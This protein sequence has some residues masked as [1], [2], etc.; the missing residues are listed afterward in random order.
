MAQKIPQT[1]ILF[2]KGVFRIK[3]QIPMLLPGNKGRQIIASGIYYD[4][5]IKRNIFFHTIIQNAC[6]IYIAHAAADINNADF[7]LSHVSF[8]LFESYYQHST[9]RHL[10]YNTK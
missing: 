4:A 10:L 8:F 7:I 5:Q 9:E 1:D 3:L 2:T 6:A